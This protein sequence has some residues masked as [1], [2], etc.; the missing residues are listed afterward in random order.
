VSAG[1]DQLKTAQEPRLAV[2]DTPVPDLSF[3]GRAVDLP[4][5]G[6]TWVYDN[7]VASDRTES[8]SSRPT[9]VLLHGWTST[10][11]LNFY[12]CFSALS[13]EFRVVALD[14]RPF[15]LDDC[16]DDVA[17]LIDQLD[18]GPVI[19]VGYSMG[20]PIAQLLWRRHRDRVDGLVL[21]ATA[22]RFSTRSEF[23]GPFGAL[24]YGMALALSGVPATL[25]R[26]GFGLVMRNRMAHRGTAP[27]AIAEWQRNDPAALVQAGFALSRFDSTGWVGSIDVPASVVITTRDATV[28]PSHQWHLAQSI[29]G[30]RGFPVAGNHRVCSE[31]PEIFV[32]TL[33][34]ACEAVRRTQAA[35]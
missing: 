23:Y 25:R 13:R 30:A 7:E 17:A 10:A 21:C 11:A 16:A 22:A 3:S 19:A 14:H 35:T 34:A 4:G 27:W 29:P 1:S 32:P 31:Q 26:Q 15:R 6:R 8:V 9:V 18:T 20:G 28:A 24:G 2:V 33:V 5:R 12:R